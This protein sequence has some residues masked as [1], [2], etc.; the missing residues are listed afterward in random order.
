MICLESFV[1]WTHK[2]SMEIYVN[3]ISEDL[4]TGKR[5][6][7]ASSFLTFVAVDE[8]GKPEQVPESIPET[9]FE[10]EL[11]RTAPGRY[12][13]RMERKKQSKMLAEKFPLSRL[14]AK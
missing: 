6:V 9:E 12:Q 10:K 8:N 4:Y 5:R 3:I 11:H 13:R 2:T 7:C 14:E 1:T